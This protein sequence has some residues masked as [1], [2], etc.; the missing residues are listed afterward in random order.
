[1]IRLTWA[2][3]VFGAQQAA[4][5]VPS[6]SGGPSARPADDLDAIARAVEGRFNGVFRGIYE[7][8]MGW[9][10]ALEGREVKSGKPAPSGDAHV[11]LLTTLQSSNF[12]QSHR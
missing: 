8:G 12:V 1:M 10:C 6:S 7:G 3:T 5:M 2:L 4:R 11:T 9:L